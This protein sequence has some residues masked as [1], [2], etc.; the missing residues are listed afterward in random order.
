MPTG[1]LELQGVRVHNL[2][3][4]SLEIPLGKFVVITGVSGSGKSSLAFDT[5]AS[6][7]R[8]RFTEAFAPHL[9]RR[10]E[11]PNRPDAEFIGPLPPTVA[12][13]QTR[14]SI[15][16]RDT[17]ATLTEISHYLQL[18]FATSGKPHCPNCGV[19]VEQATV[20]TVQSWLANCEPQ[21][22]YMIGFPLVN[23]QTDE[24]VFESLKQDGFTRVLSG[25]TVHSLDT[26]SPESAD[27]VIV[28]VDR[29]AV[30]KASDE[31]VRDSLETAFRSGDG[32]CEII[33]A[34]DA[35]HGDLTRRLIDGRDWFHARFR[36]ELRCRACD[37]LR[38]ELEPRLLS[39]RSRLGACPVCHGTGVTNLK[40][41]QADGP[42]LPC[43]SCDGKRLQA[44]ALAVT[45]ADR[46]IADLYSRAIRELPDE[47]A[48]IE[49]V[50]TERE[51]QILSE[52]MQ[53]I[54]D[55]IGFLIE[56]G[57]DY[58][59]L[60][61][62]ANSLSTG[63]ARRAALAAMLGT[64]LVNALYVLDEPSAGLHPEE[65]HR[66][67]ELI[68]RLVKLGN[69]VLVV[70]H[71]PAFFA[72]ADHI[73]ELGPG[74]GPNGGEVVW[75]GSSIEATQSKESTTGAVLNATPKLNDE[76][77]NPSAS[78]LCLTDA[79]RHNLQS[80]D[81]EFPL[82]ALTAVTGVGGSGK[83][84]LVLETLFPA[85]S[86]ALG[87]DT[88]IIPDCGELTAFE[89]LH[90]V[91]LA[92]QSP[93]GQSPRSNVSTYLKVFADIRKIFAETT[94]AKLREWTA[95][96]FSFN[97]SGGGRCPTCQGRGEITVDLQFLPELQVVCDECH[98][99][100]YRPEILDATYRGLNIAEVLELS[101]SEAFAFFRTH[102]K[103]AKRLGPLREVGLDYLCLG[104]PLHTLSGGEAQR[105][106]LA[107]AF[108]GGVKT[109]TLFLLEEATLGL[110][111]HDIDRLV[112][113]LRGLLDVGHTVIMVEQNP[114]LLRR[115]DHIIELG[116]GSG[117]DGGRV[118]A[119]G[120]PADVAG[121]AES[122]IGPHLQ[123]QTP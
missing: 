41:R 110:H 17:L 13:Q 5:I 115:V 56:A 95:K 38:P 9:R 101:A 2:K 51:H 43:P 60:D 48:A 58:L 109:R 75:S 31:R 108:T 50:W 22:R 74:A 123:T 62:S 24:S 4:V 42:V 103:V 91:V 11:R 98:G 102:P 49:S 68:Q 80:I 46:T 116:P 25:E 76:S 53:A 3:S 112:D 40:K 15:D 29:L 67:I 77:P 18:I 120:T 19:A 107:S 93:L 64:P 97:T 6:E 104:Q 39:H 61:R 105:L 23:S 33:L 52:P 10:L 44:A 72:A 119:T 117:A 55:R 28:I 122:V 37:T 114:S 59:T 21:T 81:V 99:T 69:S 63:E 27:D 86:R 78:K 118:I 90:D 82:N 87:K 34:S 1:T 111:L 66:L 73:I 8:R 12:L 71:Q 32:C 88:E 121:N 89:H 83:S 26:T 96:Q 65:T 100:R 7:G 92:D 84:S 106:K 54:R 30:G 70:E 20:D 47:L 36:N 79:R 94:E 113:C 85:V 35:E 16:R 57:L 45:L 14:D